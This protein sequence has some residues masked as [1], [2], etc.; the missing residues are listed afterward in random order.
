LNACVARCFEQWKGQLSM[1]HGEQKL[2]RVLAIWTGQS[3]AKA[4]QTWQL[5]VAITR[6]AKESS[7]AC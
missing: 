4:F 5:H 6:N 7:I 3:V 1:T 2:N